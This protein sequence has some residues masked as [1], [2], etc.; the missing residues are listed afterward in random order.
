MIH[1]AYMPVYRCPDFH[2][3]VRTYESTRGSTRG[4]RGPKKISWVLVSKVHFGFFTPKIG[5]C[6]SIKVTNWPKRP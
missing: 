6:V 3:A 2:C 4:P 5:V 1:E